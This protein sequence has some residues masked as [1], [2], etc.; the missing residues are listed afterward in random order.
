M[1]RNNFNHS[2]KTLIKDK[3]CKFF[4][5][6]EEKSTTIKQ[7]KKQNNQNNKK[8]IIQE[9]KLKPK[10]N[11][12]IKKFIFLKLTLFLSFFIFVSFNS[13]YG[14]LKSKF[15]DK[16]SHQCIYDAGLNLFKEIN[17]IFH[18]SIR[19]YF[20]ILSSF[21]VDLVIILTCINWALY[22]K[23]YLFLINAV[24]FYLPRGLVQ[25]TY[26]M[27]FPS[28]YNFSYPGFPSISVPYGVT[29]DF[30][31]SGHVAIPLLCGME[32][33]INDTTDYI[34]ETRSRI[35]FYFLVFCILTSIFE[36]AIMLCLSGHYT[37]DLIFGVIFSIYI[38]KLTRRLYNTSNIV[39]VSIKK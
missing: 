3:T 38:F 29:N 25:H 14:F 22:R 6:T 5:F 35:F 7:I 26:N 18:S 2:E 8:E 21:L 13:K 4:E 28:N 30:F 33:Y 39:V 20:L 36:M 19:D 16:N 31:W 32:V 34:N 10:K 11:T 1:E 27:P 15:D 17:K 24:L 37:V 12:Q 23:S 9:D